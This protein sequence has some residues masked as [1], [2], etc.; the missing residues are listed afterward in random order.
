MK[1][2]NFAIYI[3]ICVGIF[4]NVYQI[5]ILLSKTFLLIPMKPI[6]GANI[7][8]AICHNMA[9]NYLERPFYDILQLILYTIFATKMG[10][11]NIERTVSDS[12]SDI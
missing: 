5:S 10:L 4:F 11:T 9:K 6:F 12:R 8:N 7:S 3:E 1:N 2:Q